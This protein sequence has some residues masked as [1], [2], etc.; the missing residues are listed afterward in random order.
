LS[1]LSFDTQLGIESYLLLT[2]K[3]KRA[4]RIIAASTKDLKKQISEGTVRQ[5][6]VFELSRAR[7]T[8]PPLEDRREDILGLIHFFS[9]THSEG[10]RDL[11]SYG[12]ETLTKLVEYRWLG[13]EAE[14]ENEIIQAMKD[15]GPEIGLACLSEKVVGS[16]DYALL[17]IVSSQASLASALKSL[18]AKIIQNSLAENSGNKSK[19]SR[20][21]G[22]SRSALHQK[23]SELGI[24]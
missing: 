23:I 21:L 17:K 24:I 12:L 19:V 9:K 11:S 18:E 13:N 16:H 15:A 20:Y 5:T 10:K 14:L 22:L 6:L 7:I 1:D 3:P 4:P 8:M 2:S